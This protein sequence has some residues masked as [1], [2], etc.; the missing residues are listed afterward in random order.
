MNN[1]A[2]FKSE[3]RVLTFALAT[4]YGL[5]AGAAD[6]QTADDIKAKY[7]KEF[8]ELNAKG[9][10]LSRDAGKDKPSTVGAVLN[11][12]CKSKMG[13][14]SIVIDVPEVSMKLQEWVFHLPATGMK[15]TRVGP[16]VL[17]LPQFW[18]QEQRMSLHVPEFRIGRQEIKLHVPEVTCGDPR[19]KIESTKQA[20]KTI[21]AEAK[22]LGDKMKKELTKPLLEQKDT[23]LNTFDAMIKGAEAAVAQIRSKGGDAA[24]FAAKLGELIAQRATIVRQF[25]E[26]IAKML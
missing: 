10:R 11:I 15:E 7:D 9:Q 5:T 13:L 16:V 23:A 6:A 22:A 19:I 24:P 18:M 20:A 3:L 26:A 8:Q 25:D 1:E 12:D 21:T 2:T 14:Q 4:I 17:H